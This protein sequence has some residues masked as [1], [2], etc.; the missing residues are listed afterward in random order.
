MKFGTAR[1]SSAT[2]LK[3]DERELMSVES[4]QDI[5]IHPKASTGYLSIFNVAVVKMHKD[6]IFSKFISPVC[7]WSF[8]ASVDDQVGQTAFGVGYGWDETYTIFGDK[9]HIPM[10]IDSM[11]WCRRFWNE[12]LMADFN[13]EHFCASGHTENI[14]FNYDDP[15]YLSRNGRWYLR[16]ILSTFFP[17]SKGPIDNQKPVLYEDAGR[18]FTWIQEQIKI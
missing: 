11:E 9:K 5:I 17:A 2:N 3:S 4:V 16:G 12:N 7:L 13:N 14:V 18:F 10:R 15:L 8:G 6:V 1:F